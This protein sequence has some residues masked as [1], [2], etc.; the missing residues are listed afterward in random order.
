MGSCAS[1]AA[2]SPALAAAE[3]DGVRAW[4]REYNRWLTRDEN[5]LK[6][7][8]AK[9]NHATCW[10]LQVA[11]FA[12]LV[13]DREQMAA[14]RERFKTVIVPNQIA[15]DGSFPEELRRTKPYGYSL[16]NLEAMAGV[17]ET[18]STKEDSLW[19]FETPDGRGLRS[20]MAYMVLAMAYNHGGNA[21][22]GRRAIDEATRLSPRDPMMTYFSAIRATAEFV[23]GNYVESL[24]WA[25]KALR[26]SA[27]NPSAVR[28]TLIAHALSG[29]IDKAR[30]TLAR[31]REIQPGISLDYVENVQLF[32][33]PDTRA[34]Y[35][36][37]FKLAGLT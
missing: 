24:A 28:G 25:R 18:L 9:N 6:E 32:S 19:T 16:F 14:A 33:D 4:F 5:A 35:V 27:D 23:A 22:A 2:D 12:H 11:A 17:A 15:A 37:A 36:Q 30:A 29:D 20:A 31:L 21:D 10:L 1:C 34:R 8:D 26:E 7:R 13:G 3:S